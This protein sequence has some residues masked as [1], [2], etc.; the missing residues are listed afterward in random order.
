[1]Q[2]VDRIARAYDG[3]TILWHWLTAALV[4]E[5][6][7]GAQVIDDFTGDGRI[8]AR[9]VHIVLGVTL[10]LVLLRRVWWRA[11]GGR[12][13]TPTDSRPLEVIAKATHWGLYVLVAATVVLGLANVWVRGDSIFGLFTIP[14]IAPGDRALRRLVNGWHGLAANAVLVVAGVHACAAL[15]HYFVLRDGVLTRMVPQLRP[16]A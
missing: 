15:G 6:W 11:T 5:Q 10:A 13:L 12:R 4:V 16:R 3:Q 8:A 9:S 2:P 1:M 7:L 14:S